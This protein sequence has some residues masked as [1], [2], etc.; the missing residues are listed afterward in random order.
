M[1]KKHKFWVKFLEKDSN[2]SQERILLY[3][4]ALSL[5]IWYKYRLYAEAAATD[6]SKTVSDWMEEAGCQPDE[7]MCPT[8]WP[9]GTSTPCL[10]I[11]AAMQTQVMQK[12]KS[13]Q[14]LVSARVA[15]DPRAGIFLV[16]QLEPKLLNSDVL[17]FKRL[18][19]KRY[20]RL[21]DLWG[22]SQPPYFVYGRFS[23]VPMKQHNN[24]NN[25]NNNMWTYIA[26]V[27][28]N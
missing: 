19:H 22:L 2:D 18:F 17:C 6:S 11:P 9:G 3:L 21:P 14:F 24:N 4:S 10:R 5:Q 1:F 12:Q 7:D 8:P 26:H 15:P 25:N 27:S 20:K 23:L 28:T 13:V 16:V